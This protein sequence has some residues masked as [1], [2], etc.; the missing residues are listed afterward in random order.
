MSGG[1]CEHSELRRQRCQSDFF[2]LSIGGKSFF[3]LLLYKREKNQFHYILNVNIPIPFVCFCV[4]P[5]SKGKKKTQNK[6]M[7]KK[8]K[9]NELVSV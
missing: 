6:T 2:F 8:R 9:S 5:A 1:V 4:C 3:L 7:K